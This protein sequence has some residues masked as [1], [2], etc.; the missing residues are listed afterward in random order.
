MAEALI[1]VKDVVGG[2]P[3]E[4]EFEV[5]FSP[6][7]QDESSAHQLVADFVKFANLQKVEAANTAE[8]N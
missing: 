3:G 2:K 1:V 8:P 7:I 6:A 4:V 5:K